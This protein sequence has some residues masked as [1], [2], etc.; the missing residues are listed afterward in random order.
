MSVAVDT[1]PRRPWWR[2][3]AWIAAALL[4]GAA[5]LAVLVLDL[6]PRA[7]PP[8]PPDKSFTAG[9]AAQKNTEKAVN[10]VI[11]F[12]AGQAAQKSTR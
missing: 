4:A 2:P 11:E 10:A 12:T 5:L 1:D 8:A 9:Q 6:R 7:L 3:L